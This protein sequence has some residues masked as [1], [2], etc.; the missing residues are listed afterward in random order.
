MRKTKK[1]GANNRVKKNVVEGIEKMIVIKKITYKPISHLEL[2]LLFIV[3]NFFIL[4]ALSLRI[5]DSF[6]ASIENVR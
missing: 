6:K 4:V 2:T 3:F 5:F 1:M